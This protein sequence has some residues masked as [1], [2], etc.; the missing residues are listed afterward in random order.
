[1][2]KPNS[3]RP[4]LLLV[5]DTPANLD[6]LVDVLK[7]D[8]DLTIA[9]RG[10]QALQVLA[11][12]KHIDLILLD[13]MMPEM[14][15]YEVCRVLRADP[16]TRELP[17]IFLTAKNDVADIVH[18]FEL[19]AND[20]VSKPFHPPE[21]RA[22][23]RTHTTLRA[24]QMEIAKTNLDLKEMLHIV[25]HDVANH[26]AIV[27]MSLELA[28]NRP[29]IGLEKLLP[30]IT[31]AS[32]NGIAL[33]TL[34]R[35]LRRAD[36]KPL[37]IVSVSLAAA[38]REA[39][40][41]AEGKIQ[42]KNLTV[43]VDVPDVAVLAELCALTNSVFGNL[44]SNAIKFSHPGGAFEIRGRIAD[45]MACISIRDQGVGMPAK[46]LETLFDVSKSSSRKGTT[47]E[48]GTGFGMPLMRKFVT[49]FGGRVEVETRDQAANPADHGTTFNVWLKVA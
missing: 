28:V 34:V 46:V 23:V 12:V 18:G 22:R 38:V 25:C 24:Q 35:D 47:G 16:A 29:E 43:A 42:D 39:L 26:F 44:L 48:K 41:L 10:A 7:A 3:S 31:A 21:L 9:T 11:K 40:L 4:S 49:L 15:G 37:E 30:R 19:G 20:Y 6:I 33:T 2:P 45:G 5:D 8:Y 1:M 14:D 27:S 17:I 13:V 32:R 36:D